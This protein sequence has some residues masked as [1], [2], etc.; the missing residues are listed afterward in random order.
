MGKI[1]MARH[2][3]VLIKTKED[4]AIPK[5][6]KLER[7]NLLHQGLNHSH[8]IESGLALSGNEGDKKYLRVVEP[9]TV[10]HVEHGK[11][12]IPVGDYWMEIKSEYDHFSEEFRQVLD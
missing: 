10:D 3:D 7:I 4:F 1:N 12:E 9:L 11:G 2:G 8:T 6:I 5:S